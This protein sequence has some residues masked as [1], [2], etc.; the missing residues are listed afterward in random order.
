[1]INPNLPAVA[2]PNVAPTP[3]PPSVLR[4]LGG[5]ALT[6]VAGYG[7]HRGMHAEMVNAPI[8]HLDQPLG[9][10]V[11]T[12]AIGGTM[13]LTGLREAV[14]TGR[15]A[16]AKRKLGRDEKRESDSEYNAKI[17]K[18]NYYR[19]MEGGTK[20]DDPLSPDHVVRKMDEPD[21]RDKLER[22]GQK[23]RHLFK[24]LGPNNH[25]ATVSRK[26]QRQWLKMNVKR[27]KRRIHEMEAE[28]MEERF[29]TKGTVDYG[30]SPDSPV[31]GERSSDLDTELG[32]ERFLKIPRSRADIKGYKSAIAT[33]RHAEHVAH[34]IQRRTHDATVK[35]DARASAVQTAIRERQDRKLQKL[36]AK[37]SRIQNREDR[38]SRAYDWSKRSVVAGTKKTGR[39]IAKTAVGMRDMGQHM[40]GNAAHFAGKGAKAV[41]RAVRRKPKTPPAP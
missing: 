14:T 6:A 22:V 35:R 8:E 33:K 1:M 5:F 13:A 29:A 30:N 34:G 27:D 11:E 26:E 32:W 16:R 9:P 21:I 31:P 23:I 10:I 24:K 38:V 15:I 28:W 25:R 40:T 20:P 4:R 2:T 19:I 37:R 17:T 18:N 3:E 41:G 12:I 7:M 39:G 36:E